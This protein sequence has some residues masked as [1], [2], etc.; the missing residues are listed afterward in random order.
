MRAVLA[1]AILLAALAAGCSSPGKT[2]TGSGAGAAADFIVPG[3][4]DVRSNTDTIFAWAH[5]AGS[6]PMTATWSI[7]AAS[8]ALPAGWSFTFSPPSSTLAAAGTRSGRSYPDWGSTQATLRIPANQTAATVDV[9]LHA[10]PIAQPERIV[11]AGTRGTV[12]GPGSKVTVQYDGKFTDG[13]R[14]DQGSF[15]TTVGS[16]QTVPGFDNG[17][18]GLALGE[19]ETLHVPPAFAYGYDNAPGS[20]YEQFNGQTLL[21]TV[22]LTAIR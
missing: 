1:A 2:A 18:M 8:G 11:V 16:G 6:T 5:N 15:D 13:K 3:T 4:W 10:G 14:F 19:T 7:T 12:S 21:F 22:D 17:L 20:G 9:V